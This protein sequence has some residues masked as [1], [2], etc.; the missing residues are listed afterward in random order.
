M[1]LKHSASDFETLFFD[2]LLV[3][4]CAGKEYTEM[5]V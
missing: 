2:F 3:N 5:N 1:G 4:T